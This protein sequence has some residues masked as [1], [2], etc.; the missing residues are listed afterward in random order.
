MG[1][2]RS[3]LERVDI[4]T[5]EETDSGYIG[6]TV[7]PRLLGYVY[8]DIQPLSEKLSDERSGKVI[9]KSVKLILRPDAG[10]KCGDF[11]AVYSKNPNFEITGIDRFSDHITATAVNL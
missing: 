8:A 2:I 5:R 9:R 4:F 1:L 10:I 11:V 7:K 3:R 6:K